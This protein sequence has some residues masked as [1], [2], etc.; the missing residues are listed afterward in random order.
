MKHIGAHVSASGGVFN[1]PVRA[2]QIGADAFAL[3]VK[4]QRQWKAKPLD[5]DTVEKFKQNCKELG[6]ESKY[7]LPHAGYL[8]NLGSVV[9]E[10]AKKSFESFKDEVLRVKE[11]SL[12]KI[13][14]HPGAHLNKISEIECI[15]LVAKNI[16]RII[17]E[18]EDVIIVIENTAGDG[19]HIGYRFEHLRDIIDS[20][21]DKKR[22]GVCI[23]TCHMFA[24][25][26]DIRDK[27][28]FFKTWEKFDEIVGFELLKGVHL[29]D[30]KVEL[31]SR[32]DRHESIGKGKIGIDAF[33]L[34][35]R[36]RRFDDIPL[37]LETP[38]NSIWADE[39]K[40]L[41]KFESDRSL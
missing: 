1:A 39:I 7:I 41:R 29:N 37:I 40:M 31:G 32:V 33:K 3:F 28:S 17:E 36:D 19:T 22:I 30:S 27:E 13:N 20:V 5:K 6:F 18:T 23:D 35:M 8:I 2:K 11:L 16:N 14:V 9:E 38:N 34:L 4:N 26:Y 15:K 21:K 24:A 25:G 10:N 12:N